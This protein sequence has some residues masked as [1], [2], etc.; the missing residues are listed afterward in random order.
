MALYY[1]PT[2][3]GLQKTLGAQLDQG[4]VASVTLNNTTNIQDKAGVFVVDRVDSGGTE[5]AASLREYISFTGVSGST[6]TGLTRG[7]GGGGAD[8]D[9]AVGAVVEFVSDVV[10]Q[11][12]I[13]D[14]FLVAHDDAGTH[15]SG[16]VL[17]LPQINNVA[18]TYQ[19]VFAVS[20][21][22]ADRTV[23]LPLLT[24]NDEFVFKAHT[25]ELSNKT[26]D[27][28]FG[29]KNATDNIK[30]ATADPKRAFYVPASAMISATT[31]GPAFGQSESSTNKVNY[32]TLDFDKDA[33][34]YAHFGIASPSYWDASTVTAKIYWTCG[35]ASAS[36]TVTWVVQGMSFANDDALDQAYGTGVAVADTFIANGDV[37]VTSATSAIT[38]GGTPTAGDWLQFRIYRDISEDDLGVDAKLLG[39][40]I[41]FG[42][43]QYN[44]A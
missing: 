37:H 32:V 9:H 10:Q 31:S 17:T 40:R 20:A 7:L 21:L 15:K 1:P 5:K 29:L 11:Q 2:A 8:Q 3:N 16:S 38:I 35:A 34:E 44:D 13:L 28:D 4:T 30:V 23:T 18:G 33:D 36:Q 24:G 41:E 19:Y 6:L 43:A 39:V 12:A 27:G 22:A 14:T 42:I 25:Q 26:H